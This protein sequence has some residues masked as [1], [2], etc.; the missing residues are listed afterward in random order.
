[1]SDELLDTQ[2]AGLAA[3]DYSTTLERVQTRTNALGIST[4]SFSSAMTK[5]FADVIVGG[6]QF[7]DV[8][9]STSLQLSKIAVTQ[10]F[11]PLTGV[12]DKGLK[13]LLRELFPELNDPETR[14]G[15]RDEGG[16]GCGCRCGCTGSAQGGCLKTGSGS[17]FDL[18]LPPI[19]LPPILPFASGGVIGA[20]GY[21]PMAGGLGL[22]GEAGPEAILPLA[23]GP[24]GRLGIAGGGMNAPANITVQITT[25]DADSFRRSEA[26]VT[27]QIARAVARGQR[28][29]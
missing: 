28:S 4:R 14:R 25:P 10:A 9:K 22:A 16:G 13:G 3:E 1:M 24:D 7:D 12:I 18:L 17:I 29:L 19:R 2:Q 21:F 11:K 15:P 27:S 26:Y 23:R 6:K 5:A 8:L 20:P